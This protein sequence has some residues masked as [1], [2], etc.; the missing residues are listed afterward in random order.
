PNNLAPPPPAVSSLG[1][2]QSPF[3]EAMH[4]RIGAARF[5]KEAK[6]HCHRAPHFCI[7]VRHDAAL[8]VVAIT[9]R[10]REAQLAFFRF[11]ELTAL[12]AR[13]QKMPLGR[14]LGPLPPRQ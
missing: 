11:V 14:T 7:D 1:E 4:D 12:E 6:H 13:V 3:P 9:D 8:L 2:S 10:E 5:A